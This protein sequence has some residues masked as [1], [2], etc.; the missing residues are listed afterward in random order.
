MCECQSD[1]YTSVSAKPQ[2]PTDY[3]QIYPQRVFTGEVRCAIFSPRLAESEGGC[4]GPLDS[5]GR[6]DF[7]V[8]AETGQRLK[9]PLSDPS[10]RGFYARFIPEWR[11][12]APCG[13]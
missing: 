6:V 2:L 10:L 3:Q 13:R 4:R 7:S 11:E 8:S 5:P 9:G 12:F 1:F